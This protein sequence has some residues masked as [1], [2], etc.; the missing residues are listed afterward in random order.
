MFDLRVIWA[1][2]DPV[3]VLPVTSL[4]ATVVGVIVLGGK[5]IFQAVVG[6]ARLARAR[7]RDGAGR[8][9]THSARYRHR[10]AAKMRPNRRVA[11]ESD[12]KV[13]PRVRAAA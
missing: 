6:W 12:S 13:R 5:S 1:Y 10:A 8:S 9:G 4:I 2:V 7:W 11:T 3:T